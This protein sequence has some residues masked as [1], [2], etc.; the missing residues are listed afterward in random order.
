[1]RKD[2]RSGIDIV[3]AE[4][5]TVAGP[6]TE[7]QIAWPRNSAGEYTTIDAQMS[8]T[9]EIDRQR[10]AIALAIQGQVIASGQAW[11]RGER[12]TISVWSTS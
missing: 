4:A 9:T 12:D 1:M 5:E 8:E 11:L 7:P 6:R 2:G 3:K 10:C